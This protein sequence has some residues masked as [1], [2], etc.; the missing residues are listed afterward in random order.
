[1]QFKDLMTKATP[2]S[3]SMK[4]VLYLAAT[5]WIDSEGQ[6]VDTLNLTPDNTFADIAAR[7]A[8]SASDG[9]TC[10]V[11]SE[12]YY[13]KYFTSLWKRISPAIINDAHVMK[14]GKKFFKV[15]VTKDKKNM[16]FEGPAEDGVTGKIFKPTFAR[17]GFT[18]DNME[19]D[20]LCQ[21]H[22]FIM[23]WPDRDGNTYQFGTVEEGVDIKVKGMPLGASPTE[24]KGVEFEAVDY[25][26]VLVHYNATIPLS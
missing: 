9:E 6:P 24:F 21:Q 19:F 3:G 18:V 22:S 5:D 14:A 26:N 4:D 20:L 11:T 23:I 10:L 12:G 17:P 1:M 15:L 8:H 2:N 25:S 16:E 7:D 13:Y